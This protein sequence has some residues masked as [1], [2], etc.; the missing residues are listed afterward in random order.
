MNMVDMVIE[1][2]SHQRYRSHLVHRSTN[3]A[4]YPL[5]TV[6]MLVYDACRRHVLTSKDGPRTD[7]IQ[8]FLMAVDPQHR[9]S[10][11]TGSAN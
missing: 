5:L 6:T 7:I 11:E 10:S 9:Y 1:H 2:V 3:Y 4:K 8:I